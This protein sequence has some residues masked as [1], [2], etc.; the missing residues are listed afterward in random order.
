[1]HF[2]KNTD[3]MKILIFTDSCGIVCEIKDFTT[4][5]SNNFD[6]FIVVYDN[7][8]QYPVTS[9]SRNKIQNI[10]C[11]INTAGCCSKSIFPYLHILKNN[12]NVPC[13]LI[14]F[15]KSQII[16]VCHHWKTQHRKQLSQKQ[17]SHQV[18]HLNM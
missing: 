10:T 12:V 16:T 13:S 11:R 6:I 3:V 9:Q 18:M 7:T 4:G 17:H 1:M 14:I 15:F 8:F 5:S 2:H